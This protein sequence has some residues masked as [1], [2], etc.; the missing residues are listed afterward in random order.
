MPWPSPL[1]FGLPSSN[2]RGVAAVAR[3]TTCDLSSR[4]GISGCPRSGGRG[5]PRSRLLLGSPMS[6][7]DTCSYP[8]RLMR[9]SRFPISVLVEVVVGSRRMIFLR[10]F[11]SINVVR[12]GMKTIWMRSAMLSR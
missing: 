4:T 11:I 9:S 8:S 12:D 5:S 6:P 10:R 2:G 1:P 3:M 7:S